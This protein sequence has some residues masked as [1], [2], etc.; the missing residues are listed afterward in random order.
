[1][2]QWAFIML[3]CLVWLLFT[4]F[5]AGDVHLESG[6]QLL[7]VAPFVQEQETLGADQVQ[8]LQWTNSDE[9]VDGSSLTLRVAHRDFPSAFRKSQATPQ[10]LLVERLKRDAARVEAL[11]RRAKM[12]AQG[13]MNSDLA[14]QAT[15]Y[16]AREDS[17]AGFTGPVMSGLQQGSGEYFTRIG[18]GTPAR[19]SFMVLDTGSDIMWIQCSPCVD[20]YAQTGAVFNPRE[21]STFGRLS[22]ASTMC[23][24]LELH[25]CQ[26]KTNV[27]LYQVAYGDGSFTTG[28]FSTETL[29]FN[30]ATLK[31]VALGCGHDNEGLFAGAGGILGLGGGSLSFPSQMGAQFAKKFSYCLMDRDRQGSSTLIFGNAAVPRGTVFSPLLKNPKLN[32]F[33]YVSLTGISVGGSLL[34]IPASAFK[35]DL[36]G[37]GGVIVDSGTSVT[38]LV[39]IAYGPLRSAFRAATASLPSA[40]GYSLFD[41]CYT[42]SNKSAVTVPTVILHFQGGADVP[43]P[44]SNYLIPVD[45]ASTYCFAFASTAD[46]LSIIGNVQQQGFRVVFDGENSRL[47][48]AANQC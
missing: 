17:V 12:A 24:E 19:Q 41:T 8:S 22:C 36:S 2:A 30:G 20:C 10:E 34:T 38:R 9:N 21:S 16:T 48:F 39:E 28:E 40:G 44:A 43:L 37:N 15:S 35:M 5:A 18:V 14:V 11:S 29:S 1:M 27:C 33:Y 13:I 25:G 4:S 45:S 7:N 31:S 47:G 6:F 23:S 26:A 42:L 3:A 32:T 46:G